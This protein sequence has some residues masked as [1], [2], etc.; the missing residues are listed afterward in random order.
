MLGQLSLVDARELS[1][2]SP[3]DGFR[4]TMAA[5]FRHAASGVRVPPA[6]DLRSA[7]PGLPPWPAHQRSRRRLSRDGSPDPER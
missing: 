6:V 5:S 7:G 4:P 2:S 1:S 3:S